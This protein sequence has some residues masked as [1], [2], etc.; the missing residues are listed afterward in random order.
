MKERIE[1]LVKEYEHLFCS[2]I[3]GVHYHVTNTATGELD[4]LKQ[5]LTTLH[6]ETLEDIAKRVEGRNN[7]VKGTACWLHVETALTDTAQ[8]CRERKINK[9]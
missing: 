1:G 4:W 8:D 5:T 9:S 3:M 7:E 6:D 2:K